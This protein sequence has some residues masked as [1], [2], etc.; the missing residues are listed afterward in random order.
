MRNNLSKR[1]DGKLWPRKAC[2]RKH[3]PQDHHAQTSEGSCCRLPV[4]LIMHQAPISM[5]Q[6]APAF[7]ASAPLFTKPPAIGVTSSKKLMNF[8]CFTAMTGASLCC[9]E[10]HTLRPARGGNSVEIS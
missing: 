3:Q 2:G 6:D 10:R 1:A 7:H 5:Q 4:C 8:A 9:Q